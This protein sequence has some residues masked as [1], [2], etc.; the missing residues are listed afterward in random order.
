MT[1]PLPFF[2]ELFNITTPLPSQLWGKAE[3]TPT[4]PVTSK[5][6][7]ERPQAPDQYSRTELTWQGFS[8]VLGL[9]SCSPAL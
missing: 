6:T 1:I 4:A 7:L 2:L 8:Y 9:A 3:I 5:M